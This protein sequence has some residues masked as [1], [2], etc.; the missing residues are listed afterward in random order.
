MRNLQ[1]EAIDFKG[2]KYVLVSS[3]V[4]AF[5]EEYKNGSI[6]TELI[7]NGDMMIVKAT[8]IP[9]LANPTRVFTGYSQAS[10]K[11]TSS[12][13]NKT[14]AIENAETSAVGRALAFMGIGVIDSISSID[15]IKKTTHKSTQSLN[16]IIQSKK[17]EKEDLPIELVDNF[18]AVA[19]LRKFEIK[20]DKID[21][22][23]DVRDWSKWN[24]ETMKRFIES[25]K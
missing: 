16:E 6:Q 22:D 15:E 19:N 8:V 24:A 13:V 9:D 21:I 2:K 1:Q 10:Y 12:F 17:I 4:N 14:S 23:G 18:K 3:R 25:Y 7:I 5:N 11:D 20:G